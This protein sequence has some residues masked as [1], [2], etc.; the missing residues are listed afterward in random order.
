MSKVKKPFYKKWWV[1]LL[2]IIIVSV[3][4]NGVGEEES[5]QASD[6]TSV[7]TETTEEKAEATEEKKEYAVGDEVKVDKIAYTVNSVKETNRITSSWDETKTTDGM[8]VIVDVTIKNNDKES[9]YV[10]E[11]MFKVLTP[12]E[13]EYSSDYEL[14]SYVNDEFD[15]FIEEINPNLSKTGKVVFELPADVAE[16]DLEV[17]D[18]V[19][20]G[21][22][23]TIK[24]K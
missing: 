5:S 19:W 7:S 11:E 4:A 1:W 12:D 13:T 9:I 20:G 15:F 3:V 22:F 18:G 8:Y 23:E 17:T 6:E 10:D 21:D 24:L 16:Y 2:A 14:D